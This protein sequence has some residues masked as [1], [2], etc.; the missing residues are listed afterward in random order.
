MFKNLREMKTI[1]YEND[2]SCLKIGVRVSKPTGLRISPSLEVVV[3]SEP[4]PLTESKSLFKPKPYTPFD[5]VRNT[6]D[7]SVSSKILV[8][9]TTN[10][11]MTR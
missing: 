8:L 6:R 2:L 5:I 9:L 10:V 4:P 1:L 3:Y 7:F 11:I